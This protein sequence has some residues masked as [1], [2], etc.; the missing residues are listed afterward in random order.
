M[1]QLPNGCTCSDPS[2]FPKNWKTV[3]ASA[4]K[5][6]DGKQVIINWRIQYYF[7]DPNF[8]DRWP[9]G[10]LIIVKGMNLFKTV[11][12]KRATTKTIL[13][14]EINGLKAGYNPILKAMIVDVSIPSYEI[15]PGTPFIPAIKMAF[16]KL[17]LSDSS[18]RNINS[19]ITY[20]EKSSDK[21]GYSNIEVSKISRKH[22][23]AILQTC[24]LSPQSYNHYRAYLMQL[25]TELIRLE[26]VEINPVDKY[27]QKIDIEENLKELLT[28]EERRRILDFY[29][30]DKHFTRFLQIFFHSGSR[31]IELLR[32]KHEKVDPGCRFFK[33]KVRKRKKIVEEKRP[34]KK[35]A[36]SFW[37]EVLNE[38][39][40]GEYL[41]GKF[42]VPGT[43]ACLRDYITKKWQ[44]DVKKGLG[45]NKNMYWLKHTNLDE[46][47]A[48][49][50]AEAAARQA[51]HKSTVI[52][53]KHYLVNEEEREMERLRE[54]SNKFA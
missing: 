29:R 33:T 24:G 21:L 11:E 47:S 16:T 5:D 38:T 43:E 54:V 46:T 23:I 32:I 30:N 45:I 53:L 36:V 6:K 4:K 17:K 10:K 27:V 49:L 14:N 18:L 51:G 31:P 2:V 15:E 8:I 39:K 12:E 40:P 37:K 34:I 44:R 22:V 50:D 35:V 1:L 19:S 7:R 41:F 48:I 9:N 20:I 52:T 25:F 26:A 28:H 3:S 42:L 13:A